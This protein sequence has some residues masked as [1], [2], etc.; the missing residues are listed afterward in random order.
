MKWIKYNKKNNFYIGTRGTKIH[1]YLSDTKNKDRLKTAMRSVHNNVSVVK[2]NRSITCYNAWKIMPTIDKNIAYENWKK[3]LQYPLR[4][5]R[6]HKNQKPC[7]RFFL[8][9]NASYHLE[10]AE[11]NYATWCKEQNKN[12]YV[13]SEEALFKHEFPKHSN[14][15][16]TSSSST[17]GTTVETTVMNGS[18]FSLPWPTSPTSS[19]W[20]P[21]T[22]MSNNQ[23]LMHH[24]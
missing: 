14:K 17:E 10:S 11:K 19:V 15:E 8:S 16:S 23:I 4:S 7:Y 6:A 13:V 18:N 3:C 20:L 9:C 21:S 24:H 1:V 5:N 2:I 22:S 12:F